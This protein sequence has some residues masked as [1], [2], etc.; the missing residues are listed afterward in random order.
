MNRQALLAWLI[1]G[2]TIGS[3]FSPAIIDGRPLAFRDSAHFYYPLFQWCRGEWVEGRVPLW[4]PA[5]NCGSPILADATSSI[6]YPGKLLFTLPIDFDWLFNFYIVL[7]V[8]LAAGGSY[9]L[10]RLWRSSPAAAALAAIAYSC[11]GSVVFQYCNIVFLVGA[12]WLP[13]LVL[14]ADRML[15]GGRWVYSL[16]FA[17]VMA[18]MTL[19][20]DPQAA[21]HGLLITTLYATILGWKRWREIPASRVRP[22]SRWCAR[23]MGL[24]VFAGCA[25]FG[26]SAI[27]IL[28][29][30]E[31]TRLSDRAAFNRPRNIYEATTVALQCTTV[32]PLGETCDQS[33]LRGLFGEPRNLTHHEAIYEFSVGPWR[34]SELLWPNVGGQLFPR[35]R[36][37]FSL[38]PGEGRIWTPSLFEGLF[39]AVLSIGSLIV[40]ARGSRERWLKGLVFLGLVGSFGYYGLGWLLHEFQPSPTASIGNPVGGLYWL[41]VTTL[42]GYAYFRYPAKLLPIAALALSLLAAKG[43]DRILARRECWV[44]KSLTLLATGSGLLAIT[45]WLL[46][47]R[48]L[49]GAIASDVILGPFDAAGARHDLVRALLHTMVMGSLLGVL[50][51]VV[52]RSRRTIPWCKWLAVALTAVDLWAANSWMIVGMP[53]EILHGKPAIASQIRDESRS[54]TLPSSLPRVFRGNLVSWQPQSFRKSSSDQRL[55]ELTLWERATL[56]PKFQLDQ[57]TTLV[58]SHG[59]ISLADYESLLYVAKQH[60]PRQGDKSLTP[61]PT[62]LRLLATEFLVLPQNHEVDFATRIPPTNSEWP[63]NTTLWRMNWAFPRVW[64]VNQVESLPP[65]RGPTRNERLEGRSREVLFPDEQA[66]DFSRSAV[67]ET[68][69]PLTEWS[70]KN[71]RSKNAANRGESTKICRI[72]HEDPQRIVIQAS[73]REP[74]LLVLADAWFPGWQATVQSETGV[75]PAPIYRTNRILRGIWLETGEQTVEFCYRPTTFYIGAAISG[76]SWTILIL[77]AT[78]YFANRCR[79]CRRQIE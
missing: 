52:G 48:I 37:W 42:P 19:G 39:P 35:N 14:A 29:S 77:G 6:F 65:L 36:R 5:E 78:V 76:T 1:I 22:I 62:A 10:A 24:I 55:S 46:G 20:G 27:Q 23:Q 56:L 64:V 44:Q 13:F 4:N 70:A 17:V 63:E 40:P 32:Q 74:G 30:A 50:T 79:A 7:H 34:L 60:G 71:G 67:V 31:A 43:F 66:R 28:P 8:I 59:S 3:F 25:S 72:I 45:N 11:G 73:L 12:A 2:A 68:D 38:L 75:R 53:R 69:R 21:Y 58:E 9:T 47:N 33:I 16:L 61:Q 49:A 18:L 54:A 51:V 57:Q 26:L 15:R 41:L